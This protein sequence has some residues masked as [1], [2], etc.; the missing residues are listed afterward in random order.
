M[1]ES[2]GRFLL[3]LKALH[4]NLGHRLEKGEMGERLLE[5][6]HGFVKEQHIVLETWTSEL[7]YAMSREFV[8]SISYK[9]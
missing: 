4:L 7:E 3:N 8:V 5:G 6:F 2:R 1:E 9:Y